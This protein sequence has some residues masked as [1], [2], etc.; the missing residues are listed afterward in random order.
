MARI[1]L[2]SLLALNLWEGAAFA[3]DYV[4]TG[5]IKAIDRDKKTLLVDPGKAKPQIYLC[6]LKTDF[7][8]PDGR[9]IK[10]GLDSF[11]IREGIKV[12]VTA[13]RQGRS[14]VATRVRLEP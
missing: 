12:T 6:D 9:V 4:L 8:D 3:G 1:L 2:A 13:N 5:T 14:I 10:A 7:L 11:Q